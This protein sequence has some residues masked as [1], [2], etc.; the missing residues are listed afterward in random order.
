MRVHA[1]RSYQG[2]ARLSACRDTR[3]PGAGWA[4]LQG[5]THVSL[6]VYT[7]EGNASEHV[8]ACAPRSSPLPKEGDFPK[9]QAKKGRMGCEASLGSEVLEDGD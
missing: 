7:E 8:G 2:Q 9:H 6:S 5:H 4:N 1:R 3:V